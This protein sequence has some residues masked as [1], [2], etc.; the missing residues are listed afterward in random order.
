M[1]R[2]VALIHYIYILYGI[3]MALIDERSCVEAVKD[4]MM[5]YNPHQVDSVCREAFQKVDYGYRI[6]KRSF[7]VS[8][9]ASGF[10]IPG[11]SL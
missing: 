11:R 8:K 7:I 3:R 2:V 4:R 1:L 6:F 10:D 5:H 9:T